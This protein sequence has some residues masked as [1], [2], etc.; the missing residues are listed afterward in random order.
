[1]IYKSV[2]ELIGN[3]PILELTNIE[4][5]FGLK[6]RL[7]AKLEAFNPAASA[8]DR[9][10]KEIIL[11]AEREGKIKKGGTVIEAT[12]GNT[13]IALAMIGAA[14]GYK[15]IIVMPDSMSKERIQ[16]ISAYGA[17]I[18]LTP[19]CEGMNGA[20]KKAREIASETE[21]SYLASQFENPANPEAHFL[22]TGPEIYENTEGSVDIFVCTIGTGGTISG[23]SKYLKSKKPSVRVYG[24]EPSASPLIS[25]GKAGAHKIQGIGAN[26]VPSTFDPSVCDEIITVSDEDA[27]EYARLL[28]KREGLLVGISSG[29]ALRAAVEVAKKEENKTVVVLFP[30][31]GLRYFSSDL[32]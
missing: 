29:A 3:T 2:E 15:V 1:M 24:V 14:R 4:K 19:G 5:E 10:A 7:L 16:A 26:F 31:T 21:N 17:E 22:T 11:S 30:D 27:Y 23:T 6:T 32:F 25:Q 18:V 28:A 12:S 20:V 13:G 9:V 8:K